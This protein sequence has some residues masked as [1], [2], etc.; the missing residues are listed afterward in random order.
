MCF[1]RANCIWTS[2][3]FEKLIAIRL[4]IHT[5]RRLP[6]E[7]FFFLQLLVSFNKHEE[8][9]NSDPDLTGASRQD[10]DDGKY[11]SME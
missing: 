4:L 10:I 7:V 3:A 2:F 1:Y 8:V 6:L 5:L 11:S 9:L